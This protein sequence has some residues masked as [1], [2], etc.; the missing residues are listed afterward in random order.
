[1]N[2]ENTMHIG[3]AIG[4]ALIVVLLVVL[5]LLCGLFGLII[6]L[7]TA[8]GFISRLAIAAFG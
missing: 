7:P 1:M 4:V 6:E 3:I 8:S 2:E 5:A